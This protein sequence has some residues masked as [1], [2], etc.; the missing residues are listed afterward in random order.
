MGTCRIFQFWTLKNG[1]AQLL[2]GARSLALCPRHLLGLYIA[3]AAEQRRFWRDWYFRSLGLTFGCANMFG[4]L[5]ACLLSN[6]Y[7]L[8]WHRFKIEASNCS[9]DYDYLEFHDAS[10]DHY[11]NLTSIGRFC[12]WTYPDPN[13]TSYLT[14]QYLTMVW[15]TNG[16]LEDK[17]WK[18]MATRIL[19][20][21]FLF[22]ERTQRWNNVE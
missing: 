21:K 11:S 12:G 1:H 3:C 5:F 10:L 9:D 8:K 7:K 17:G 22:P 16:A 4:K 13:M 2:I 20:C 19:P 6:R 18:F 14:Q 15:Q